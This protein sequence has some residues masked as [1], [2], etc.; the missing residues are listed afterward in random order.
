MKLLEENYPDEQ[1]RT[2]EFG[3]C[4]NRIQ[5]TKKQNND[6]IKRPHKRK[7]EQQTSL[8]PTNWKQRGLLFRTNSLLWMAPGLSHHFRCYREYPYTCVY[9]EVTLLTSI[10][11]QNWTPAFRSLSMQHFL[12]IRRRKKK[13]KPA[14]I[15]S[16]ELANLYHWL[17]W[18]KSNV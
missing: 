18:T 4:A 6:E 17:H 9:S 12:P 8:M 15:L 3:D 1:T 2:N 14:I 11:P 16:Q 7:P 10:T 13:K 5:R